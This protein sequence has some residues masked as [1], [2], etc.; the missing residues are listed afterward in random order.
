VHIP[1]ARFVELPGEDHL[2]W[3][4]GA[5]GIAEIQEFLTGVRARVAT[6]RVLLTLLFTDIV[7]STRQ[8]VALGDERWRERLVRHN[9]L[10]RKELARFAGHEVTTTGDGILATFDGPAR[11]IRCADAI[12]RAARELPFRIRLGIHT[13]ECEVVGDDVAGVSVHVAARVAGVSDGHDLL[14]TSTVKDLV[15]GS[16][17]KFRDRG[18]HALRGL[19][20][21]RHL[22]DV[23]SIGS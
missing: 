15:A 21:D 10:I 17:I 2:W 19:E 5:D 12:H 7:E 8:A 23:A 13:G 11:A 20:G 6:D 1:G 4:G 14:V 22:Y 16:G 18:T 3:T 9:Q